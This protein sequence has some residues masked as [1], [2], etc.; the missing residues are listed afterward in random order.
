[1]PTIS[2]F[3]GIIIRMYSEPNGPHNIPHIH[4][5]YQGENAVISLEGDLIEGNIPSK[6]LRMVQAWIAIHEDELK[7]NWQ[8]LAEGQ[9]FFRIEPL[10]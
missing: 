1:M 8:L 7:A 10:K 3:Y 5:E 6:K 9:R 4:A 2:M